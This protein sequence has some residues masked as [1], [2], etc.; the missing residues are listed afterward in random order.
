M[1]IRGGGRSVGG[2]KGEKSNYTW[3]VAARRQ[4]TTEGEDPARL[5]LTVII[6]VTTVNTNIIPAAFLSLCSSSLI[7]KTSKHFPN[8]SL[9]LIK[10]SGEPQPNY[11]PALQQ[12]KTIMHL[13]HTHTSGPIRTLPLINS[14][15]P[16]TCALNTDH[17]WFH[18]AAAASGS[19][20]CFI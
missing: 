5:R 8:L 15:L 12:M 10:F 6:R 13:T 18:K 7:S 1:E 3:N 19:A 4:S 17:G 14:S 11:C 9:T 2:K 20:L 16:F